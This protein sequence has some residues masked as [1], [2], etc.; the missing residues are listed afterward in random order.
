MDQ[1]AGDACARAEGDELCASYVNFYL[2]GGSDPAGPKGVLVPQFGQPDRDA[3]AVEVLARLFPDR[4]VVPIRLGRAIAVGGGNVHCI[5]AQQAALPG[6]ALAESDE[7]SEEEGDESE[8]GSEEESEDGEGLELTLD[9]EGRP[10]GVTGVDFATAVRSLPK[11]DTALA[12]QLAD[13]ARSVGGRGAA[14]GASAAAVDEGAGEY[15]SAGA[16]FWL[17]ALVFC[18]VHLGRVK[19]ALSSVSSPYWRTADKR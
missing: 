4:E 5:T 19:R 12:A 7:E 14:G 1:A 16:T 9:G 17:G 15:L 18:M 10:A 3:A 8:E 2:A 11:A 13:A 6:G